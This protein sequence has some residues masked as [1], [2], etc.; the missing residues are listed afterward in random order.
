MNTVLEI[1]NLSMNYGNV[2]ALNQVGLQL[3]A[4]KIYG[5]LGRNG[6][7]KT[8]LLNLITSRIYSPD[9]QI[10]LFGQ[11]GP[12]NQAALARICYM[13]EKNLFPA[14]MRVSEIMRTAASFYPQF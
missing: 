2:Q 14:G 4:G 11:A 5:L 3:E 13:P 6:A 10:R 9:G 8:T 1:S 7:G 12:D